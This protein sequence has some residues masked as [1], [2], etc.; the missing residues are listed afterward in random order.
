MLREKGCQATFCCIIP[1][2]THFISRTCALG[3]PFLVAMT[4]H[5]GP[6]LQG[7]RFHMSCPSEPVLAMR[8]EPVD[9]DPM[10]KSMKF[11]NSGTLS[12]ESFNSRFADL[13]K[14]DFS[15]SCEQGLGAITGTL[16]SNRSELQS[17]N[18]I[19]IATTDEGWGGALQRG[20]QKQMMQNTGATQNRSTTNYIYTICANVRHA[21][22]QAFKFNLYKG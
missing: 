9:A 10:K 11:T 14:P 4:T 3:C 13:P 17:K 21:G 8:Q 12:F 15:P 16:T 1:K 7:L 22:R 20:S 2:R 19:K 5:P 6:Q 18:R